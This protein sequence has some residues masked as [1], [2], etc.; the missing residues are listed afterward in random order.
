M[1]KLKTC[2]AITAISALLIAG[3]AAA[4]S[5]AADVKLSDPVSP[6]LSVIAYENPMVL[7]GED[8]RSVSFDAKNFSARLGYVPSSITV[9]SLPSAECG[10]LRHDNSPVEIG[11]SVSVL[12]FS[13]LSFDRS[14]TDDAEFTFT[15]DGVTVLRLSLIHI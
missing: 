1:I 6:G 12:T 11:Q 3:A 2:A 9:L 14:G 10:V 8:G 4:S 5:S 7:S 13:S 15:P